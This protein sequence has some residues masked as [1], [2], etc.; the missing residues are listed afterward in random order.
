[1]SV[2]SAKHAIAHAGSATEY[3]VNAPETAR[4]AGSS[5]PDVAILTGAADK[6][7]AVGLSVALSAQGLHVEVVGGDEVVSPALLNDPQITFLNLRDQRPERSAAKKMFRIL[8]HYVKLVRYA[9]TTRA[10]VFH[11]LW[12]NKFE[13]FDRTVLMLYYRALGK[14]I[15]HTAHNVNAR[16]RDGNDTRWHRFALGVQ[17]QLSDHIFVHSQRMKQELMED[18]GIADE[19]ATVIPFGINNT[20]PNTALTTSEARARLGLSAGD[21]VMLFF[22]NIA[23]SQGLAY[24][25]EAF[26]KVAPTDKRYRLVI[27][28]RRKPGDDHWDAVDRLLERSGVRERVVERIEYIPDEETEIYFKAADVL[29]LPYTHIFQSGVL[30]LGFSFGL[31]ALASDVGALKDEIDEGENGF[32]FR[33]TDV[34]DLAAAIARYF[35]SGLY[36]ALPERRDAIRRQAN[37]QH[38]WSEVASITEQVYTR[39][40]R[41]EAKQ[42]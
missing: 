5:A 20:V 34:D 26:A 18:F 7:Y 41:P 14:R 37:E 29:V 8:A 28:G 25:V 13:T 27:A 24:L 11:I 21:K 19:E 2:S 10:P 38:S 39:V 9:A 40:R 22:G 36:R 35:S 32:V 17:Y 30:F 4:L 3:A 33:P 16:K 42:R 6:P 23:P 15:V 12:N 1:M 31:P